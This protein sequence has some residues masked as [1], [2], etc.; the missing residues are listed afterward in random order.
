MK[1][2]DHAFCDVL[3]PRY[4]GLHPGFSFWLNK[5]DHLMMNI[6]DTICSRLVHM[7]KSLVKKNLFQNTL[8]SLQ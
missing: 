5:V 6:D 7:S 2:S 4:G 1:Y 8:S 3:N